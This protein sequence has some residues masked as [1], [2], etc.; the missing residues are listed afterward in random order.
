MAGRHVGLGVRVLARAFGSLEI[1]ASF[2]R[3]QTPATYRRWFGETPDDFVFAVKGSRSLTHLKRLRDVEAALANFL[4]SGPLWL[5]NFLAGL[6][7]TTRADAALAERAPRPGTG[8]KLTARPC[9]KIVI[10]FASHCA[11]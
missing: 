4:A 10:S 6:P 9:R 1:N 11:A 7:R 2:Y 3:L 5:G 8:W